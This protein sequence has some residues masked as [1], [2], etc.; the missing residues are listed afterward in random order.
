MTRK[1][2]VAHF[3]LNPGRSSDVSESGPYGSVVLCFEASFQIR[4]NDKQRDLK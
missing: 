4:Q 3:V 1:Q 2:S